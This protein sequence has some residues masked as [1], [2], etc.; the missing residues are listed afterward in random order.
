MIFELF[1]A[2]IAA[3]VWLNTQPG[4]LVHQIAYNAIFTASVSTI[5]FNANP[6]M[7][8]DGYFIL[9]DLLEVP[10]LMQRSMNQLKHFFRPAS[11]A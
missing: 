4:S 8:F 3:L 7:R 9:A 10:N 2:S 6:L 5:L 11:T 1:V